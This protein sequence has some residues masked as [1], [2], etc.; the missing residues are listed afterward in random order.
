MLTQRVRSP[1]RM[2]DPEADRGELARSLGFIRA[3]NRWLGGTRAVLGPL[4]R[5]LLGVRPGAPPIRII[6]LGTGSADIPLAIVDWAS[7]RGLRVEVTAVDAHPVTLALAREHVGDVPS[8]ELVQANCLELM[9][10]YDAGSFDFAH[11]GMF[12]HHLQDIEILTVLRIMDRL[13]R[14]AVIWNDLVRGP[15]EKLAVRALVAGRT[16]MVRHDAIVSV[17]AGFRKSEALDLADRAG[18][19]SPQWKRHLCGRFTVTSEK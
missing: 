8:I 19:T 12:L 1:E 14:R 13:A 17:A 5:W 16:A 6:D 2:D 10:R 11:A 18:W 9:D 15:I 7:A 3:V 4:D